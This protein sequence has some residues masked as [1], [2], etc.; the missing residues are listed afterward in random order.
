VVENRI[1]IA[2]NF[3]FNNGGD[4]IFAE[5][6]DVEIT[7]NVTFGNDGHGIHVKVPAALRREAAA[8]LSD[9]RLTDEVA[10]QLSHALEQLLGQSSPS[11]TDLEETLAPAPGVWVKIR[12]AV[13]GKGSQTVLAVAA[14]ILQALQFLH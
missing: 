4:G 6:T 9:A 5:A 12:D 13:T 8:A 3:S 14:V 1:R 2:D 10:Q 11:P 7:G